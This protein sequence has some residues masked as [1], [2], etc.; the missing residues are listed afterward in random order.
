[1]AIATILLSPSCG[2]FGGVFTL[3]LDNRGL[4]PRI[5]KSQNPALDAGAG[6][7]RPRKRPTMSCFYRFWRLNRQIKN[8]SSF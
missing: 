1:M 6:S 5:L 3:L 4:G 7:G 2:Q 8:N